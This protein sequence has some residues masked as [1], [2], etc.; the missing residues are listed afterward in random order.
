MCE[1][2]CG[3]LCNIA[4]SDAGKAACVAAGAVPAI[5]ACL[6][7]HAGEAALSNNASSALLRMCTANAARAAIGDAGAVPLLAA[8]AGRHAEA[9]EA[10][11][12]VLRTLRVVVFEGAPLLAVAPVAPALWGADGEPPAAAARG[13]RLRASVC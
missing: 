12:A 8:A 4:V 10:A 2:G 3:A 7:A 9:R 1:H 5:T 13:W 6:R 11:L